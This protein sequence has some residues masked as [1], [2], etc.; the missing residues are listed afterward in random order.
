MLRGKALGLSTKSL[1]L[2]RKSRLAERGKAPC[3]SH[4]CW[5]F[6]YLYR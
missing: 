4:L 3:G 2:A 5:S 6:A 1:H